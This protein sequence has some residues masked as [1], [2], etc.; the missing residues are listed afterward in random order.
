MFSSIDGQQYNGVR[1]HHNDCPRLAMRCRVNDYFHDH[2]RFS[3]RTLDLYAVSR[4]FISSAE[5]RRGAGR[6]EKYLSHRNILHINTLIRLTF[7]GERQN[8]KVSALYMRQVLLPGKFVKEFSRKMYLH[9]IMQRIENRRRI[10]NCIRRTG[11][12][13]LNS[14]SLKIKCPRRPFRIIYVHTHY[15]VNSNSFR[16]TYPESESCSRS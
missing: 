9:N 15:I 12:Q 1:K 8:Q 10:I 7:C 6:R 11:V 14:V 4:V 3:P 13:R 2:R 16:N 5:R